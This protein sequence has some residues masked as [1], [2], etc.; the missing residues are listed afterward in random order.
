MP[1]LPGGNK[2]KMPDNPTPE[3]LKK[4]RA[5]TPPSPPVVQEQT[6]SRK[7]TVEDVDEDVDMDRD[8]APGGDA[9]YY[10][11]E[12]EDGRFFGGGL[13]GEQKEILNTF[14]N[15]GG[16]GVLEDV[17]LFIWYDVDLIVAECSGRQ[18]EEMSITGIRRILLRFER[19]ANKNQDQRSKYPDDPSKWV[20]SFLIAS[21]HILR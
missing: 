2:R 17:R 7:A 12:D 21:T 1:K 10:V 3:M 6:K 20:A 15:A 9:D 14:E 8:F 16:E 18:L 13:T 5:D 19:A 4:M 11:E